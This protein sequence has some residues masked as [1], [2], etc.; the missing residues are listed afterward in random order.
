MA[1]QSPSK[2]FARVQKARN[3]YAAVADNHFT[4]GYEQENMDTPNG[5]VGLDESGTN[6]A[7]NPSSTIFM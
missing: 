3:P 1:T 4:Q 6:P 7:R 5:T 2:N